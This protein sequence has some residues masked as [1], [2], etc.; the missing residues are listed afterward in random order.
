MVYFALVIWILACAYFILYKKCNLIKF[1]CPQ[2]SFL[3][4]VFFVCALIMGLRGSTVGVDTLAYM[5][6]F[7][8]ISEM[9]F[10]EIITSYNLKFSQELG[11]SFLMK[12][13]SLLIDNYYF[14]QL[15]VSMIYCFSMAKF[16]YDNTDDVFMGTVCF[17]GIGL[18]LQAFN[19]T[20]QL[21]AVAI[22]VNGW[23]CLRKRNVKGAVIALLLASIMHSS[24][25]L[26]LVTYLI[27]HLVKK[28]FTRLLP[29]GILLVAFNYRWILEVAVYIFPMYK[30][31]LSGQYEV[32]HVGAVL[33]VWIIVAVL[34]LCVV[35]GKRLIDYLTCKKLG[36]YLSLKSDYSETQKTVAVL[37]I[38]YVTACFIGMHFN[39]FERIGLYF[40]PF[41]LI[42]FPMVRSAFS[43]SNLKKI[44]YVGVCVCF[45]CF[46]LL[47]GWKAAQYEYTFFFMIP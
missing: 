47:T 21:F 29:I 8:E 34:S 9:S 27:Y 3:V 16:I 24:G 30:R 38:V 39:Y 36:K 4:L 40:M 18:Y 17:V 37:C 44:Y 5:R 20:Q 2:K 26:F 1:A 11:Y 22:A 25:V 15:V 46:F 42:L 10:W 23:T 28:G 6:H 41:A 32:S 7:N 35:Y 33:I 19:V 31:Y 12:I 43:N 45:L 14:F 13:T